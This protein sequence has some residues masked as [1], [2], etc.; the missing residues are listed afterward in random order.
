[1]PLP[2][3]IWPAIPGAGDV[4]G[5]DR[6]GAA[7]EGVGRIDGLAGVPSAAGARGGLPASS[8]RNNPGTSNGPKRCGVSGAKC[9]GGSP[10]GAGAGPAAPGLA[11]PGASPAAARCRDE[12]VES[13]EGEPAA[14]SGRVVLVDSFLRS[15][16]ERSEL[17]VEERPEMAARRSAPALLDF[18]TVKPSRVACA[19]PIAAARIEARTVSVRRR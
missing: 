15:G 10:S 2:S 17:L 6:L 11:V 3:P 13:V 19:A 14:W 16:A 18:R 1:M 5:E 12:T 7:N 8:R 9:S 4:A